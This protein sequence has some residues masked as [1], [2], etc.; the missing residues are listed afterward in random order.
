LM[1]DADGLAT[2]LDALKT[3]RNDKTRRQLTELVNSGQLDLKGLDIDDYLDYIGQRRKRFSEENAFSEVINAEAGRGAELLFDQVK[4]PGN[5]SPKG[6]LNEFLSLVRG[7]RQAEKG[8]QAS[9][10]GELFKRSTKSD[11]LIRQTGDLAASAFDPAKFRELISN[12]RIRSLIQE[13]FPNNSELLPGLEKMAVAAFETSNFTKGTSAG[14]KIDP[15]SALS[16]EAWNN[17]GRIAGLQVAE[18]ISFI[19]S[20]VAAGAGSR[21]FGNIG[22]NITG[23][24]IKDILINAALNPE[25]AVGLARKTSQSDGFFKS[26]AR[27]AI[28]TVTLRGLRPGAVTPVLKRGEEEVDEPGGVGPQSSVQPVAAPVRQV[29]ANMPPPRAP[30]SGSILSQSSPVAPRPTGQA[31][32]VTPQQLADVGLDLFTAKNG[33]FVERS[34][35]MSVKRKPRQLVG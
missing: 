16:M 5:K 24:K 2:Q 27:A 20:L 28:D 26:L 35:I 12:P 15:Q 30:A 19:N 10:I 13:A 17:L 29:A 14:N 4:N 25:I 32:N 1:T 11:A 3:L 22:K 8:L 21:M 31:P 7:N 9:I 6:S 23:N 34:G 18:R 33:G